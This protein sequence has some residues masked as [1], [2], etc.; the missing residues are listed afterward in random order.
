MAREHPGGRTMNSS[1]AMGVA[2]TQAAYRHGVYDATA[3]LRGGDTTMHENGERIAG[4]YKAARLEIL[5][6]L[7]ASDKPLAVMFP[8]IE[9]S[10]T[11]CRTVLAH[12]S[13]IL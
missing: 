6:P 9:Q 5:L 11:V 4:I 1:R 7:R 10:D 13:T 3:M 12:Q 2:Q 8:H